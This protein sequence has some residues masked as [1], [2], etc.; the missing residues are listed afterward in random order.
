MNDLGVPWRALYDQYWPAFAAF[1]VLLG[2]SGLAFIAL[3]VDAPNEPR[4]QFILSFFGSLTEDLIFFSLL[5]FVIILI[6]RREADRGR[7]FDDKVDLLFDA[8]RLRAGEVSYLRS[9]IQSISADCQTN[10]TTIDVIGYDEKNNLIQ[11][12]VSR[13][14]TVA[15]YLRGEPASYDFRL[16]ITPDDA[17]GNEPCLQIFPTVTNSLLPD[18]KGGFES[19]D[20]EILH[21]GGEFSGGDKVPAEKKTLEIQPGQRREFRTRFRFW[22]KVVPLDGAGLVE[23]KTPDGELEGYRMRALKH[24]DDIT[25]KV[26]NSLSDKLRIAIV[27]QQKRVFEVHPGDHQNRAYRVE[28][29]PHEGKIAVLFSVLKDPVKGEN[30]IEVSN[31]KEGE[32]TCAE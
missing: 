30:V 19:H 12:D 4:P 28:N 26:R 18:G 6:Q 22:Q 9:R 2:V 14:F 16:G 3:F 10:V 25:I 1:A 13:T 11:I 17:C 20:D 29:L 32:S 27:G 7:N 21:P 23:L 5:G 15:N 8:K 31:N 24:W